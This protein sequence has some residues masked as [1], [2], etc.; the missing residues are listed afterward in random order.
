MMYPK[1]GNDNL[2]NRF[3][4]PNENPYTHF[5]YFVSYLFMGTISGAI[6]YPEISDYMGSIEGGLI[7]DEH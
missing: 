6:L 4:L 5:K 7:Y 1:I 2:K 3:V